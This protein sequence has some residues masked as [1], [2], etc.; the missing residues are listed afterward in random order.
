MFLS[1]VRGFGQRGSRIPLNCGVSL[2]D[3]VETEKLVVL[4]QASGE[5]LTSCEIP[6]LRWCFSSCRFGVMLWNP[7][8][9]ALPP[10]VP[11]F[12]R[13]FLPFILRASAHTREGQR[14]REKI[15]NRFHP[16]S[17]E[18]DAGLDPTNPHQP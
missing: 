10:F 12:V 7:L 17:S 9:P 5:L 4:H 11:L 1:G 2:L 14:E 8:P 6:R 16:I 13:S 18:L 3:L 15:L